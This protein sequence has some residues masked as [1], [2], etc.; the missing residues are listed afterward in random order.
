VPAQRSDP[1]TPARAGPARQTARAAAAPASSGPTQRRTNKGKPR[2]ANI[3][4]EQL[5][6]HYSANLAGDIAE[7][8]TRFSKWH[9]AAK[10][11]ATTIA[12]SALAFPDEHLQTH[13]LDRLTRQ[14]EANRVS[15]ADVD[16]L[17][18]QLT[19]MALT[20]HEMA[21]G[22]RGTWPTDAATSRTLGARIKTLNGLWRALELL[23][24]ESITASNNLNVSVPD[25]GTRAAAIQEATAALAAAKARISRL[26]IDARP[27]AARARRAAPPSVPVP[28]E[29]DAILAKAG[30]MVKTL[31]RELAKVQACDERA[32][33]Q[34]KELIGLI[35]RHAGEVQKVFA[36]PRSDRKR[37]EA[38]ATERAEKL[39]FLGNAPGL[40]FD[41]LMEELPAKIDQGDAFGAYPAML[42]VLEHAGLELSRLIDMINAETP[43]IAAGYMISGP[44]QV[45][46]ICRR[47]EF[48]DDLR[49][50]VLNRSLG[51]V[52][53]SN[54]TSVRWNEL[55]TGQ[56]VPFRLVTASQPELS[57]VV[58]GT[59]SQDVAFL[60]SG[61]DP[62][63]TLTLE[64][65]TGG[66]GQGRG[67]S[68]FRGQPA[69]LP[70]D[71]QMLV[72]RAVEKNTKIP[73]VWT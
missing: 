9:A 1:R 4:N 71:A 58:L 64:R 24:S 54:R 49:G 23:A 20:I 35:S 16:V 10:R 65:V 40:A 52:V 37:P 50:M 21:T 44:A 36:S 5:I 32:G 60:I 73:I 59:P 15:I 42:R 31:T 55:T 66:T 56:T 70:R 34:F 38:I 22:L 8:V 53:D 47:I 33:V 17:L 51:S 57:G 46:E 41:K 62:T 28:R 63:G 18:A 39:W 48:N 45:S 11:H 61:M 72:A 67:P 29:I 69:N 7:L 12:G 30:S 43:K 68:R 2:P 13:A 6:W 26:N 27:A 25:T 14:A 3:Q 19:R